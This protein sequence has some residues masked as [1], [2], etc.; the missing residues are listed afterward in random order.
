MNN[1]L[2]HATWGCYQQSIQ[3]RGLLP[4]QLQ[5]W[6]GCIPGWVY[7]ADDEEL[8]ISF[9]EAADEVSDDIYASGILVFEVDVMGLD[10]R[11]LVPDLN[12]KD[13]ETRKHCFAYYGKSSPKQLKKSATYS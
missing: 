12:I 10:G 2:Y 5:T 13:E 11:L 4:N 3:S 7:L 6:P 8:A 9:C 1:K